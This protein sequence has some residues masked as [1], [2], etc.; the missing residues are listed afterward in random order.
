[1]GCHTSVSAQGENVSTLG[2]WRMQ[3]IISTCKKGTIDIKLL[4]NIADKT[5]KAS[6]G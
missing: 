6:P 1:M 5:T 3:G 2:A 4:D